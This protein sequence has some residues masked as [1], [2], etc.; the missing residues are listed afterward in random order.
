MTKYHTSFGLVDLNFGSENSYFS[1]RKPSQGIVAEFVET[2]KI[3]SL[4]T[5]EQCGDYKRIHYKKGERHFIDV[6]YP[7][8]CLPSTGVVVFFHGGYW[9]L[10][11]AEDYWFVAAPITKAGKICVVVSRELFPQVQIKEILN[12]D[13]LAMELV[14][15]KFP[16]TSDVTIFGHSSGGHECAMLLTSLTS[17]EDKVLEHHF[18]AKLKRV[19][20]C[21]GVLDVTQLLNT[22]LNESLKLSWQEAVSLS[23]ISYV[24]QL[25]NYMKKYQCELMFVN[26]ENEGPCIEKGGILY[27]NELK[28]QNIPFKAV[29]LK[30]ED[31]FS[32]VQSM[33]EEDSTFMKIVLGS[34]MKK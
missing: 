12:Q 14:C 2:I 15:E 27:Q 11:C 30:G 31:H 9:H 8:D 1:P 24:K 22:V 21:C 5:K 3:K 19:V 18:Q 16:D 13:R 7:I 32:L 34:D 10:N 4:K 20:I 33:D 17:V 26:V 28:E 25:S 23:P 29:I 6:F